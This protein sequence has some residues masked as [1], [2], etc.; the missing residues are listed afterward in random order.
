[1]PQDTQHL[2]QIHRK[3]DDPRKHPSTT[4]PLLGPAPNLTALCSPGDDEVMERV[5][6]AALSRSQSRADLRVLVQAE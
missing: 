4:C 5:R 3:A 2:R 1:M 6:V